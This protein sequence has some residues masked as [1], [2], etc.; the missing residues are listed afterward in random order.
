MSDIDSDNE[1]NEQLIR[2][3]RR[4][5]EITREA[6][7]LRRELDIREEMI[8]RNN[9]RIAEQ[10]HQLAEI[11]KSQIKRIWNRE[12]Q[13]TKEFIEFSGNEEPI[14]LINQMEEFQGIKITQ[15][16]AGLKMDRKTEQLL[17]KDRTEFII[18]QAKIKAEKLG[19]NAET[20]KREWKNGR[21]ANHIDTSEKVMKII[22]EEL[23]EHIYETQNWKVEEEKTGYTTDNLDRAMAEV[24]LQYENMIPWI[25]GNF[26]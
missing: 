8:E 18:E 19:K 22:N 23:R 12:E 26:C 5:D 6:R 9:A 25:Y 15:I 20:L 13:L 21:D 4:R 14:V 11:K 16:E 7:R 1:F 10:E 24:D 17:R 3:L 2:L